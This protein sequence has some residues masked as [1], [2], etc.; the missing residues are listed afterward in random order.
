MQLLRRRHKRILLVLAAGDPEDDLI[1]L[2]SMLDLARE[3]RICTFFDPEEP[4]REVVAMLDCFKH[5]T[6]RKSW[7]HIGIYYG[8]GPADPAGPDDLVPVIGKLVIVK[9]RLPATLGEDGTMFQH[10]GLPPL[11]S[12]NTMRSG[13]DSPATMQ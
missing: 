10:L 13:S 6:T 9:N 11:L 1:V 5:D 7:L 2:K 4:R 8:W 12:E 3:A